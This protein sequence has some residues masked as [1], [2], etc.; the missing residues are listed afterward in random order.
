MDIPFFSRSFSRERL[1]IC[2]LTVL[3][4]ALGI[5]VR[6]VP[7][8]GFTKV[9]FDE[10]LYRNYVISLDRAGLV[11]YP[12]ICSLYIEK[13]REPGATTQLPPTRFLYVYCGWLVKRSFFGDA[14]PVKANSPELIQTDPALIALHRTSSIFS[15]LLFLAAGMCAW[16]MFGA[17]GGLGVL[18][19]LA[20]SPTQIHM[21]QHALI[22][23]FFAFWATLCVWFLWE[24]LR[25]PD[26][27]GWLAAYGIA[28]ALMVLTK[29]NAFFVFV[30]LCGLLAVNRWT[31]FGTV[32]PRLL[33][34]TV[35]GPLAGLTLLIQLA[36]GLQ[37]FI[38]IYRLLVINAENFGYAIRTGDGPWHRYLVD[39]MVVNPVVL[40]LAIG[41]LFTSV[42]GSKPLLYLGGFLGFTYLLMCNVRYGMNLRYTI[43]WELPLCALATAQIFRM[44]RSFGRR[45]LWVALALFLAVCAYSLR[46]YTI[47]FVDFR[48]YELVSEGLL[49]AVK[50]LK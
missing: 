32:S 27:W 6:T 16:R 18:A 25:R 13:Q 37:E 33:L 46:Q 41:G 48:L 28:L 2:A 22:D 15:S 21:G 49:R 17:K 30:G 40:C 7:W 34:V 5:F 19:L 47:F 1:A 9:G 11:N 3:I 12:V 43:V 8:A 31:G 42:R 38:E 45:E 4:V 20:C 24:N 36:G 39:L 23:G 26:H 10:I 29:E 14:P 44:A 35:L 50:I